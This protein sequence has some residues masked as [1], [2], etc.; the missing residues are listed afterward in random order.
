VVRLKNT[1]Q[2]MHVSRNAEAPLGNYCCRVKAMSI[3]FCACAYAC[4]CLR[5]RWIVRMRARINGKIFEIVI[6]HKM[7][8]LISSTTL[9]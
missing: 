4:A 8:V 1:R 9:I 6:E 2:A 7:C 5:E 3:T